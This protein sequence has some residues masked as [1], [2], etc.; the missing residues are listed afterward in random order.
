MT[1]H[2]TTDG[3][4]AAVAALCNV[5]FPHEDVAYSTCLSSADARAILSAIRDGKVPGLY[6]VS[7]KSPCDYRAEIA[8]LSAD[9]ERVKAERDALLS[10]DDETILSAIV[11]QMPE[12]LAIRSECDAL[13]ARADAL[14]EALREAV[15]SLRTIADK[16]GNIA[17]GLC[18][19]SQVR[20]F[21]NS[22][23]IVAWRALL[24][25]KAAV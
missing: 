18:D 11:R 14:G 25:E 21:A 24:G 3:D 20:G 1:N 19:M 16:G 17:D 15:T 10:G 5:D 6:C 22:R 2:Q 9:L 7:T 8:A 12:L 4:E 23:A 13:R